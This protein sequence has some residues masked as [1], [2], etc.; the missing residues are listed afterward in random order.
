M[1]PSFWH[2]R[3]EK[4][5]L[6]WQQEQAHPMLVAH[7]NEVASTPEARIFL[8]LCGKT[9]DIGWLLGQGY[10]VV[11]AELSEIAI[12][13]LFEGL[14]IMPTITPLG[15]LKHYSAP[16]LDIFVGDIFDLTK[17]VLGPVNAIYDRAALVALPAEMRPR[18]AQHLAKITG[19][20]PQL[21]IS[22]DYDQTVMQG[23]PFSV[24]KLDIVQ[25]YGDTYAISLLADEDVNGGLKGIC[26]AREQ[27]WKL[28]QKHST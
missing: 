16:Q 8:P 20:A 12:R 25:T 26:P 11:G 24:P 27:G 17:N 5:H 7:L 19:C 18:Y 2:A 6:G 4:N 15:T 1:D 9:L 28:I 23:P 21:L 10:R 22:F 14:E 13:Q 3:W